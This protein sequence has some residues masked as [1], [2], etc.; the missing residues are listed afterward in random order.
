MHLRLIIFAFCISGLFFSAFSQTKAHMVELGLSYNKPVGLFGRN[1]PRARLG[2]DAAYLRQLQTD[3]PI[4]WGLG[5]FYIPLQEKNALIT[6]PLDFQLVDFDYSTSTNMAGLY[7]KGRFYPDLYLGNAEFYIEALAG[8]KLMI[9]TT[10][11]T[12]VTDASSTDS[13]FESSGFSLSYGASAGANY[14]VSNRIFINTR[15]SYLPGVS[16]R[17]YVR[18]TS[19][20]AVNSSLDLFDRKSSPTDLVR[21]EA[22]VMISLTSKN[23][24]E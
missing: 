17:Y 18:N 13:Q 20:K 15:I 9:A 7:A 23:E 4:F 5:L 11:K 24:Q 2:F 16:T 1:M 19:A 22:G 6:E 21:I 3:K 8:F 14:P 10:S 12:L